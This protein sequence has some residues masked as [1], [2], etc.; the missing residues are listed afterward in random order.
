[1]TGIVDDIPNSFI[2][3]LNKSIIDQVYTTIQ[4]FT[5][6]SSYNIFFNL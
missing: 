6:G 3:V 2:A 5:S 1:M 4:T